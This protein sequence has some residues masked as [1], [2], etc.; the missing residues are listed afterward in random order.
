MNLDRVALSDPRSTNGAET[1]G[2]GTER[3][4]N[5]N[6]NTGSRLGQVGSD[7]PLYMK[8]YYITFGNTDPTSFL[9]AITHVGGV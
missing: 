1:R 5:M 2:R 6:K 4:G 9:I 8:H 7:M 3:G